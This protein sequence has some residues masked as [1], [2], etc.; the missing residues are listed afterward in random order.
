MFNWVPPYCPPSLQKMCFTSQNSLIR[1][2]YAAGKCSHFTQGGLPTIKSNSENRA[3]IMKFVIILIHT[4]SQWFLCNV[5]RFEAISWIFNWS[6][7]DCF[8]SSVNWL[9]IDK[10]RISDLSVFTKDCNSFIFFSKSHDFTK[11]TGK[12][13]SNGNLLFTIVYE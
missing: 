8:S 9:K 13:A 5:T 3:I 2:A 7:S 10:Y 1:E 12:I 11:R 4:P 6:K